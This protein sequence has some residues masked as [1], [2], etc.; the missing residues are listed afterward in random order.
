MSQI[1]KKHVLDGE[2]LSWFFEKVFLLRVKKLYFSVFLFLLLFF[3][4]VVSL[5]L[6]AFYLENMAFY[7]ILTSFWRSKYE[8]PYQNQIYVAQ[9]VRKNKPHWHCK[10]FWVPIFQH[11]ERMV[12]FKPRFFM[13]TFQVF[14]ELWRWISSFLLIFSPSSYMIL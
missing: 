9:I 10:Y 14:R 13:M 6:T 12:M 3:C 8:N 5:L 11:G 2:H 7:Y 4:F 1:L